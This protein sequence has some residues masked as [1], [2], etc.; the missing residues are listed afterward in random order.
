MRS[1]A[2]P[3][4][5]VGSLGIVDASRW[6]MGLSSTDVRDGEAAEAVRCPDVKYE[7]RLR[8]LLAT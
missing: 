6:M 1:H 2:E 5:S 8:V 3:T 4:D 7:A